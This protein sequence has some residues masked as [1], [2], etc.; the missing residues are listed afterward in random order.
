[1]RRTGKG[2]LPWFFMAAVL[3]GCADVDVADSDSLRESDRQPPVEAADRPVAAAARAPGRWTQST[4]GGEPAI[5]Y[6]VG[7]GPQLILSC[8]GRQGINVDLL[9]QIPI[10]PLEMMRISTSGETS[11]Y[12]AR[13]LGETRVRA[14]IPAAD[15][16]IGALMDGKAIQIRFGEDEAV[17]APASP[18]V[19]SLVLR[20]R[21]T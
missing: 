13:P 18:L 14:A 2:R 1:M 3:T 20:C 15:T 6:S 16:M 10:P 7:V 11:F 5:A 17:T 9:G 21:P 4:L 8:D 19:P 12:A